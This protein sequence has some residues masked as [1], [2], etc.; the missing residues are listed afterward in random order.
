M[1]KYDR[2]YESQDQPKRPIDHSHPYYGPD[3]VQ[4]AHE[5]EPA[6]LTFWAH[7]KKM[8]KT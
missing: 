3:P 8:F 7:L 6:K 1:P 5:K 2:R 4:I